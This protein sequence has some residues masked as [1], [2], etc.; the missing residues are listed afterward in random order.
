MHL[1]LWGIHQ[2]AFR[3]LIVSLENE[4]GAVTAIRRNK[5]AEGSGQGG[6]EMSRYAY[7]AA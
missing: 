1:Q 5:D 4:D 7:L 2:S 6:E 3:A